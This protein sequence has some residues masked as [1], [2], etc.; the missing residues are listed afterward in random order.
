MIPETHKNLI[1][2]F[3]EKVEANLYDQE[4]DRYATIYH[5]N[6]KE[7]FIGIDSD[8]N[9]KLDIVAADLNGDNNF[10]I[11]ANDRN[12]DGLTDVYFVDTT[13]DGEVDSFVAVEHKA[14]G[15]EELSNIIQ[16]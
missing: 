15:T 3:E 13:G 1:K 16:F 11:I 2:A 5:Q 4:V 8:G 14:D 6:S 10:E 9:G 7:S 12:G